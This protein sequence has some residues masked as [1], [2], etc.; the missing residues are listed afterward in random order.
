[1]AHTVPPARCLWLSPGWLECLAIFKVTARTSSLRREMAEHV[2]RCLPTSQLEP[3]ASAAHAHHS[4]HSASSTQ[5]CSAAGDRLVDGAFVVKHDD[6]GAARHHTQ[7]DGPGALL[8]ARS[9]RSRSRPAA[10]CC[11]HRVT[12]CHCTVRAVPLRLSEPWDASA[13]DGIRWP[14]LLAGSV[15]QAAVGGDVQWPCVRLLQA[16]TFV[17]NLEL[18]GPLQTRWCAGAWRLEVG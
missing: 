16:W 17:V 3:A 9:L 12:K 15:Q 1:M 6:R 8:L 2:P 11:P 7:R 18:F 10:V 13:A 14:H 4:H 5:T